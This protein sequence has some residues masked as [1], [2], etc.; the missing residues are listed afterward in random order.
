MIGG[1]TAALLYAMAVVFLGQAVVEL[2]AGGWLPSTPVAGGPQV[3]WLGLAPTR[4]GL[5]AQLALAAVPMLAWL[6]MRKPRLSLPGQ[7]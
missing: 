4:Q 3:S 2:Q 6:L 7:A 1:A 5:G